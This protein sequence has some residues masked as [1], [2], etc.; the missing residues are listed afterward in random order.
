MTNFAERLQRVANKPNVFQQF[1]RGVERETLRYTS[2]GDLATTLH[3]KSLGS[4]FTNRWITTDF[5]E[6]L[7]EFITPVSNDVSV[8]MSQLQDI[9]HF[10]QSKLD[11][12]KLWP[13]YMPCY[14]GSE[15]DIRRRKE[16]R[17]EG[18]K[19]ESR[20]EEGKEKIM[21]KEGRK[22]GRK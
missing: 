20:K 13:L 3:P 15:D 16:G 22:E 7:L 12:E 10:A 18:R 6:S 11:D 14:V 1:G 5:S 19:E 4:A 21:K 9:H 8:L 17:K 2:G